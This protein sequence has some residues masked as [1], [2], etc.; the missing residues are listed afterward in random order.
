MNFSW[1]S[2]PALRYFTLYGGGFAALSCAIH[3][4]NEWSKTWKIWRLNIW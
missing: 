1:W 2:D 4:G 3:Y